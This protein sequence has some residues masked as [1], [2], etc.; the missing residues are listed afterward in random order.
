MAHDRRDIE[1]HELPSVE[2]VLA[3]TLVLMTGYSQALQ[4]EA[5]PGQRLAMG[6]NLA[7]HLALLTENA[8]LSPGFRKVLADLQARWR[9]MSECTRAAAADCA[10]GT[11]PCG[12]VRPGDAVIQCRGRAAKHLH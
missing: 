9:A 11:S 5:H 3:C 7:R 8:L 2:A 6:E 10:G 4:A 1:E 12:A